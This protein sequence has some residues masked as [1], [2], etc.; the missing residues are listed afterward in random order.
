MAEAASGRVGRCWVLPA[1]I[2]SPASENYLR[3]HAI[4]CYRGDMTSAPHEH[5]DRPDL[6]DVRELV[7]ALFTVSTGLE[8]ARRRIPMVTTLTVLQALDGG[9][10][11]PSEVA[12]RLGLHLSSVTRQ[13]WTLEEAGHVEVSPDPADGRS[14]QVT[15]TDAGRQELA[16]LSEIGIGRFA[17]FV[18]DWTAEDVRTLSRLLMEFER[19]KNRAVAALPQPPKGRRWPAKT[20]EVSP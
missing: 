16:R 9:L 14:L 7:I 13:V 6:S 15:V 17:A 10:S 20:K 4:N 3:A 11:R 18:A 12:E 8:R 2:P 19:S 5:P 1:H